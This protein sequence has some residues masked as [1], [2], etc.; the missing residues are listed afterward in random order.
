MAALVLSERRLLPPAVATA[1]RTWRLLMIPVVLYSLYIAAGALVRLPFLYQVRPGVRL[2]AAVAVACALALYVRWPTATRWLTQGPW[3]SGA[4][5]AIVVI[6]VCGD[7]VQFA[8][9]A[10]SRTY[11]NV[12]ASRDLAHW[13]PPGTLV[14]GKLANG[15]ALENRIRPVFVGR[16]FGNYAERLARPDIQF[17]LTY[18]RPRLGY[19]GPVILEVLDGSPGWTIVHTFPVSE[20]AGGLDQ[21]ALIRKP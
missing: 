12:T 5:I 4:S 7:V 6:L 10:I 1:S 21:A 2:A 9:W 15:L 17:V 19:E 20:T 14:H 16:G 8:Q 18:T 3:P 13:L 11:R